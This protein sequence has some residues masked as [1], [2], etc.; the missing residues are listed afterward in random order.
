M[1]REQLNEIFSIFFTVV[2]VNGERLT[3]VDNKGTH[4]CEGIS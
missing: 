4:S 3:G 2:L 1:L